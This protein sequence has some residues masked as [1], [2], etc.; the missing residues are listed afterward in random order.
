MKRLVSRFLLLFSMA[1]AAQL[2]VGYMLDGKPFE[3]R[4]HLA[5]SLAE[6]V[7]VVYLGDSVLESLADRDSDRRDI[8]QML[9]EHLDHQSVALVSHAGYGMEVYLSFAEYLSRQP[10]PPKVLVVP[11]NLRSFSALWPYSFELD[12]LRL[13]WGDLLGVGLYRPMRGLRLLPPPPLPAPKPGPGEEFLMGSY[14]E[15]L[16]PVH[17]RLEALRKLV[18]A[19]RKAKI[20]P[21]V[22]VTPIDVVQ[23]SRLLGPG[24]REQVA[25][26]VE[27]CRSA[28]G[29]LLDLSAAVRDPGE[30]IGYEHLAQRGRQLV[31]S[32]LAAALKSLPLDRQ[33]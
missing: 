1:L 13:A 21:L 28:A 23:G 8:S 5:R 15:V 3:A 12:R 17:F 10:A 18:Q 30:F 29:S 22:Y 32:E 2:P 31:A 19:C 24:F 6:K 16:R 9:A 25:R 27:V 20:V 7:D 26:N 11:I 33:P 4:D 14:G